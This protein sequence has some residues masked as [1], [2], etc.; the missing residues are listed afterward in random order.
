ME[1]IRSISAI[2]D[3]LLLIYDLTKVEK[4]LRDVDC[5]Y[6][7]RYLSTLT[8]DELTSLW[9]TSITSDFISDL[10]LVNHLCIWL[11]PLLENLE[12]YEYCGKVLR[13]LNDSKLYLSNFPE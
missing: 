11:I 10:D 1:N 9:T 2:Q 12:W 8:S 13:T 4:G 6:A 7:A 5:L 3:N